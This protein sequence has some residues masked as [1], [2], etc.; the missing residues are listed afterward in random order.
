MYKV[1]NNPVV[2]FY[3]A[4]QIVLNEN[5]VLMEGQVDHLCELASKCGDKISVEVDRDWLL[6]ID[7]CVKRSNELEDGVWLDT[8]EE[9]IIAAFKD[10]SIIKDSIAMEIFDKLRETT[11][12]D[13]EVMLFARK[14]KKRENGSAVIIL[15]V[16]NLS[17]FENRLD[18]LV[19]RGGLND[20]A[21]VHY[22]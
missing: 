16:S 3:S 17:W 4:L 1:S 7:R 9:F 22:G 13:E 11:V 6:L 5:I 14:I 10:L 12:M 8:K 21:M 2:C 19:N 18:D 15:H 20:G